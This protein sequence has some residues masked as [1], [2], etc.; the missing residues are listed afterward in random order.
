M[1]NNHNHSDFSNALLGFP[2]SI[3]KI[4]EL[5]QKAYDIG[6][7]GIS[8]TDHEGLQ[9]HIKAWK[10]YL[11]MDLQRDFKL[12][13]GNE[14]YLMTE[15]EYSN[16]K[17][18]TTDK[19]TP[20]YHFVLTAL[21]TE[22]HKQIR[23]LSTRAWIRSAVIKRLMR[24]PTF[25][26]DLED[27]IKPNQG[28]VIGS[29]ACLG[30]K[31]DQLILKWKQNNDNNIKKEIHNFIQ[32]CINTFG[33]EN[34]YLEIQP[35][36]KNN[37]EQLI[38]NQVM[39][40]LSVAYDLKIIPTTDSHYLSKD[41][42]FIHKTLLNSKD[43]DREVDDF[44]ATAY[45]M[46][47]KELREYLHLTFDD[48]QIDIMY[49]NSM[50]IHSRVQKYDLAHAPI[51]PQIPLKHIPE[52]QIQHLFEEWY[53]KYEYFRWYATKATNIHDRY[54]FYRIEQAL[55]EKVVDKE[56]DIEAYIDRCNTEFKE[57][58]IISENFKSSMASYYSTFKNIVQ[59][60]W[61]SDSLSMPGRGSA[62]AFLI[63][64]L[65]DITQI[66]PVP[67]GEYMPYWRHLSHE[68]KLEI[69]DIDNDSQASK[70]ETILENL[71]KYFG[72]DKV[73]SVSTYSTLTTKT[74]IERAVKG[75]GLNDDLAGYLKSL[76]PVERGAI[77]SVN[78]CLYGNEQTKRKPVKEF[79]KT[80][81]KYPHLQDCIVGL[82]GLVIN[83]GVHA[84]GII[85]S[86]DPYINNIGGMRSP[87]GV[88]CTS[89]DLHD[90]EYC[91][92]VKVDMLT[93]QA[94]D[95]IRATLDLLVKYGKIEWQGNIKNTY[96]KYIHPDVLQY[97]GKDMWD[98]V[99]S[100]YSVFQFDT[101]ISVQALNR[102]KPQSVMDLSAANSLLRLQTS[103]SEQ[104]LDTYVRY[105][106]DLNEWKKDCK[107]WGLT[108]EEMDILKEYLLDSY[109]LADSQEKV[110]RL[111]MDDRVAGFTLFE[112][113]NLRK[114]IAKKDET[115]RN[116]SKEEFYKW[117]AER[118]TR[119]VFLDY[120]WN[121]VFG[122]SFGYSFSSIH[123][124]SYSVIALQE[125]NL[126]HFYPSIFWNCACL[127]V[128][129]NSFDDQDSAT[130]KTIDYGKMASA[131]YKMIKY[132]TQ[133]KPP[134][135][136][137][138]DISFTPDEKTN[139]ILFGLGGISGINV[140]IAKEII[141]NR[142]YK[143]FADF[144][145]KFN[146]K[147]TAITHSKII[148]LIKAGCFDEF[149]DDRVATMYEYFQLEFTPKTSLGLNNLNQCISLGVDLPSHLVRV[150][151]FKKYVLSKQ[152]FYCN[153]PNFK[154]KKHYIVEEK[155]A[156]PFLLDNY[157]IA[158]VENKDYY[159]E[160]DQMI[161]VDKSL[162][163]VLKN[164]LNMLLTHLN[165]YKTI[166]SYN[167][168]Y[169]QNN[170]LNGTKGNNV[171][172]WSFEATSYYHYGHH[173]LED[174]DYAEYNLS[175][176]MDLSEDPT[177]VERHYSNRSWRQYAITRICGTVVDKDDTK[178]IVYLLTPDNIVVNVKFQGEQYSW[179]A[180]TISEIVD[181]KKQVID[182]S[183]FSRGTL[184]MITGY[185]NGDTFRA[186]RYKSTVLQ[187]TVT[188][189]TI[190]DDKEYVLQYER[191]KED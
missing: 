88:M 111:S 6:L 34:F 171:H 156:K 191:Y 73:L 98:I 59:I 76:I 29:S 77:W 63:T 161:I 109:M 116:K 54:F 106:N 64:Y 33:K 176:F 48:N 11:S 130:G 187:H 46:D 32:W 179:Y 117:G 184:L 31:L 167:T 47:E 50:S 91:G 182:P 147:G 157:G 122:K 60:I 65:L 190:T 58:K 80:I 110:M 4:P 24:R 53:D 103:S 27:I 126:N 7:D 158:L 150:Y 38:V 78:D 99:K 166:Q 175:H 51:I 101:S 127:T 15:E 189:I 14:I 70:R 160:N 5:I 25:Y 83:R 177:F 144:Y 186:K 12:A 49:E 180:Q 87:K 61:D 151:K 62:C 21:D 112:S 120:V 93:V 162:D 174:I 74:A 129:S 105:K 56:L 17:N 9:G 84:S 22:G 45:L 30:S 153:D 39:W 149:N 140:D 66:D 95:K 16:N 155:Y 102:T 154:S 185:R 1:F 114:G 136:N 96:W 41:H 118:G 121:E 85:I 178:H 148:K 35:C 113:N 23:E 142:P 42:V 10:Y 37:N 123:S 57:L 52:F 40:D 72:Y 44:Y 145:N 104:P 67:L 141:S 86:N 125:I 169:L 97:Q 172:K 164:D 94:A 139:S 152:F 143:S 132:G 173:E 55:K 8:L 89:Y 133:I 19:Y 92:M 82:E 163:K 79:I 69:S 2:D 107:A 18:T 134:S 181:D 128:E 3:N 124:Y 188:K 168:L 137:N 115:A 71:K 68:R 170:Y 20:Y 81:Q 131:I 43:G 135:I 100:I 183:W 28:H 36:K 146:H 90:C 26:T 165:T 138:S 108:S 75:L 119:K 13:L 159:Y